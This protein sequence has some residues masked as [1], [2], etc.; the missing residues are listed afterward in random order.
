L[1]RYFS[2]RGFTTLI[3]NFRGTGSS[4]GNLDLVDWTADLREVIDHYFRTYGTPP[5]G[6]I[7]MGFSA[8]AAVSVEVAA[9]DRR[10]AALALGAC[11]QDFRFLTERLPG[12]DLWGWFKTAGMFRQ[13]E[14]LSPPEKWLERFLSVCPADR[15]AQI[16][17]R[18]L[19]IMHG[20]EDETVP[21]AH[22]EELYRRAGKE[23]DKRMVL[24]PGA[25]HQLRILE[26][27]WRYLGH[28]LEETATL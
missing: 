25:G 10:V 24:F 22:A 9:H 16:P 1:G 23:M 4:G 19:L 3:F 11:P 7:L 20:D 13:P 2:R 12:A 14:R 6:L 28:W 21:C 17:S 5:A 18:R 27:V 15:I 26:R 8:G